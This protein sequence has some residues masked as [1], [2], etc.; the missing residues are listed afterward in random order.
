MLCSRAPSIATMTPSMLYQKAL[1][2]ELDYSYHGRQ[3]ITEYRDDGRSVTFVTDVTHFAPDSF[4]IIYESP[5]HDAGRT[6]IEDGSQQWTYFPR[7]STL[8]HR[9]QVLP[10][11]RKQASAKYELLKRNYSLTLDPIPTAVAGRKAFRLLISP[12]DQGGTVIKLWIDPD[13]GMVLRKEQYHS[14]GAFDTIMYFSDI[15]VDNRLRAD[16]FSV[17]RLRSKKARLVELSSAGETVIKRA[18]ASRYLGTTAV[19]PTNLGG[20][21]LQSVTIMHERRGPT[22]HL[23]Y[24][25]GLASLSLFESSRSSKQ[26]STI[27]HSHPVDMHASKPGRAVER[28]SYNLLNWDTARLNFTLIGDVRV[29]RLAGYADSLRVPG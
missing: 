4:K 3:F 24:S 11:T 9:R 15:S 14:D 27:A 20:F 7:S 28:Y 23:R 26:A 17:S 25:D 29:D 19:L 8:L 10:L 2:A 12:R 21:E 22:L 1:T 5:T 18:D 13:T 6:I 16:D